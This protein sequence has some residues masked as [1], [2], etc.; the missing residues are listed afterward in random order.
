MSRRGS[1]SGRL[2]RLKKDGMS[3]SHLKKAAKSSEKSSGAKIQLK[4]WDEIYPFVWRRAELKKNILPPLFEDSLLLPEYTSAGQLIFYDT[5]TTGLSTGAGTIPFLIGLGRV[6]GNDFEIIQ[7]FLADYPGEQQL[8]ETLKSDFPRESLYVSYNGKSYDSHLINT[9]FLLNRITYSYREEIDLLYMSRRLWKNIL[10]NCRLGTIE[11]K[12][13]RIKRG[14]DIPGGEIPDVWFDFLKTGNLE[15]LE[16][17]FSHNLQDIYTLAV[18]LN[19]IETIYRECPDDL[20]YDK[21]ALAKLY[22]FHGSE[23]GI[24]SLQNEFDSGKREAGQFLSLFYKRKKQ[25][26]SALNIWQKLNKHGYN[27]FAVEELAKYYE[28]I[29]KNPERALLIVNKMLKSPLSPSGEIREN[30]LYRKKRLLRKI[31]KY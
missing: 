9:R 7:Y 25:W 10:E 11:E 19:A 13:L 2:S 1:L 29:D 31:G 15:K 5:E 18:L 21:L 24:Q 16:L 20:E 28:H 22:L 8:L 17:V 6:R 27:L 14:P 12:I 26:S 23:R 30:L 3:T 4:G